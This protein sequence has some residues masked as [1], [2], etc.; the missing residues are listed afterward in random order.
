MTGEAEHLLRNGK[1]SERVMRF[2]T[3]TLERTQ[4]F[5]E[6]E[7]MNHS[8]GQQPKKTARDGR[9][10]VAA[11]ALGYALGTV[12]NALTHYAPH[13]FRSSH[14]RK[15]ILHFCQARG[16]FLKVTFD[17]PLAQSIDMEGRYAVRL[18]DRR[19]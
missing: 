7:R 3:L 10:F 9:L 16:W 5:R 19:R 12:T 6:Q 14:H 18:T 17:G 11:L 13:H 4:R 2:V 15:E 8:V 1:M